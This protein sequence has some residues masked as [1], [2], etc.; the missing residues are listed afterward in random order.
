MTLN[1][2]YLI[3][4]VTSNQLFLDFSQILFSSYNLNSKHF[5]LTKN[6]KV[7]NRFYKTCF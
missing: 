6:K 3:V 1:F 7:I 2:F 4:N 5:S